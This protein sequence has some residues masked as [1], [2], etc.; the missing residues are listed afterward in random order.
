S[1]IEGASTQDF[2]IASG[3]STMHVTAIADSVREYV[4]KQTGLKPYNYDGYK[5]SEWIV[6]DYGTVYVHIFLPESR[7]Y[8][9]LE[10]LWND[11]V[12][13]NIPD[14]D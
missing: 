8:Y 2:V 5:N 13:K 6:I 10:Q 9:N 1:N 7:E 14:L 11:A 4:Q 3:S 12:I